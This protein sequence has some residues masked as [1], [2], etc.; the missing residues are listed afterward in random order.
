MND[1]NER[2][3]YISINSNMEYVYIIVENGV[4]YLTAYAKFEDAVS[5]VKDKHSEYIINE[6]KQLDSLYDIE[7]ILADIN[8]Q[9]N[10]KTGI[11]QLYIEK[12]I[13][14][15]ITKLLIKRK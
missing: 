3:F 8:V 7:Y 14:I 1:K 15:E 12:G 2:V 11:T 6:I 5:S 13:N 4:P 9:E 10:T